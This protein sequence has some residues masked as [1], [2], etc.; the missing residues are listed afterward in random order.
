MDLN[1]ITDILGLVND[2][3][4]N[5]KSIAQLER[6]LGLGK[7]TLRKKLNREGYFFVKEEKKFKSNNTG[8]NK[9]ERASTTKAIRRKKEEQRTK[10]KNINTNLTVLEL[11]GLRELLQYKQELLEVIK[12]NNGIRNNK[13]ISV[14]KELV[15]FDKSNRKKATFNVD[16]ELL[17]K[18]KEYE[19]C[20]NISKSDVVNIAIKNYLANE[21]MIKK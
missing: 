1:N 6:D 2:A 15:K 5:G 3:L 21:G 14:M 9:E 10:E 17:E 19:K 8:I 11:E 20:S 16:L 7:D 12:N 4:K 18:L 13:E